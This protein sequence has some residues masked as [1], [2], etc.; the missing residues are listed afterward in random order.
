[1]QMRLDTMN[2]N[3]ILVDTSIWIEYFRGTSSQI[4]EKVDRMIDEDEIYIPKIVMA[5]LMQGAKSKK[6]LMVIQDFLSA[7]HVIDQKDDTWI[8]AGKLSFDLKKKGKKIHLLD[9]YI[10]VIAREN[11][12]K[13]FTL[14]RHF[15]EIQGIFKIDLLKT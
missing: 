9:C 4:T 10:A 12:C 13:I 7:L 14:N 8:K 11:R 1:M 15:H 2:A 3:R 5:E 6:E